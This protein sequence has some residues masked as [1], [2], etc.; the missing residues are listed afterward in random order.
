MSFQ[1][2]WDSLRNQKEKEMNGRYGVVRYPDRWVVIDHLNDGD[3]VSEHSSNRAA[4]N[5]A[6]RLT[7]EVE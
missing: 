6:E 7:K 2:S 1:G 5:K 3:F 4:W